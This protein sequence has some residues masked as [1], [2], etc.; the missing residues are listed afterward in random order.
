MDDSLEP[1]ST[2]VSDTF[3][4][5]SPHT[6]ATGLVEA[7]YISN[8]LYDMVYGSTPTAI[9]KGDQTKFQ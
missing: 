3:K 4:T 2:C 6:E 7:V 9:E 1:A 8:S 5:P